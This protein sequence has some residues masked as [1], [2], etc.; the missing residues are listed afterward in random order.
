MVAVHA[1]VEAPLTLRHREAELQMA[2]VNRRSRYDIVSFTARSQHSPS[3]HQRTLIT[4]EWRTGETVILQNIAKALAVNHPVCYLLVL[5]IN[6]ARRSHRHATL[7]YRR[8]CCTSLLLSNWINNA[9]ARLE[10]VDRFFF[11]NGSGGVA[12]LKLPRD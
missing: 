11:C 8:A 6:D 2:A 9:L 12:G 3:R 7:R 5:V 1:V 10:L 4:A